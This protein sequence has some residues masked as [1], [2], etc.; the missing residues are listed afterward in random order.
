M[1][2]ELVFTGYNRPFY[3]QET[4]DS[5]NSVR[6]LALWPAHF[7]LEPSEVQ[8]KMLELA[9]NLN[10]SVDV[11]VNPERAGVLI[12]PWNALDGAFSRGAEFVVLAEDDVVVSQDILEYFEW[13]T[14]EY[15]T[16]HGVLAV[17]AFSDIGGNKA[18]Q[19]TMDNKFS[20]LVWGTW[21]NRW[22]D[23]LRDSWDKDYSTGKE[24]GSEAGWDWNINRILT[25]TNRTVIK[26]LQ[27]RSDHIGEYLGT[28]MTPEFFSTSRGTDFNQIRG[29]VRYTE[30]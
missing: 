23:V 9:F 6:N 19:I 14:V 25:E 11:Q 17:N 29:R 30:V 21:R 13:C 26:P 8:N 2:T 4:I 3:F 15:S 16:A 1:N 22:Y 20:P 5:W 28:H 18:N 7:Y 27:S 12:N 24:D 10:T